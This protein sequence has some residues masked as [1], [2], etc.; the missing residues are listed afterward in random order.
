M[1]IPPKQPLILAKQTLAIA[2]ILEVTAR[3]VQR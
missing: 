1:L 2:V 3:D